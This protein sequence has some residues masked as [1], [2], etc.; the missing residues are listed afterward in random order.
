MSSEHTIVSHNIEVQRNYENRVEL[1]PETCYH[2]PLLPCPFCGSMP[3]TNCY[4]T[5]Y[6]IECTGCEVRLHG[7]GPLSD[8]QLIDGV[9]Y[10]D[11]ARRWNTR[12]KV[13]GTS[14]D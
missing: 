12:P 4:P 11:T 1:R 8:Q 5:L 10:L 6:T 2:E 9:C 14:D 7:H 13:E 3:E